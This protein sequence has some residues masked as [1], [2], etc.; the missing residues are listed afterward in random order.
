MKGYQQRFSYGLERLSAYML[1]LPTLITSYLA[2][3][4]D[5]LEKRREHFHTKFP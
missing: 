5:L 1:T 3:R 4:P 2:L